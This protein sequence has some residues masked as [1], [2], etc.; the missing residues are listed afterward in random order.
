MHVAAVHEGH[1]L[2]I[3]PPLRVDLAVE[4]L[5]DLAAGRVAEVRT[6]SLAFPVERGSLEL[7]GLAVLPVPAVLDRGHRSSTSPSRST[8]INLQEMPSGH[9]CGAPFPVLTV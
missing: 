1:G 5:G 7:P 9:I 2:L 4:G 8:S 3:E 6:V